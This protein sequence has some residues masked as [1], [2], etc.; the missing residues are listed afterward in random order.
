MADIRGLPLDEFSR[1]VPPGWR[2]HLSSYPLK[3]YK[4][5]LKLWL[6]MT[7]VSLAQIGPTVVGR[8]KGAAYRVALKIRDRRQDGPILTLDDAIVAQ[9][10]PQVTDPR[11]GDIQA[12]GYGQRHP[13]DPQ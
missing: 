11:T 12:E 8:S 2:P 4:D 6:R 9:A 1:S 3:D 13:A 10:E 7:D 5:K